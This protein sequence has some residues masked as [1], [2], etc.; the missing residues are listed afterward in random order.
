MK[1]ILQKLSLFVLLGVFFALSACAKVPQ[2]DRGRLAKRIMQFEPLP[3]QQSFL[4]EVHTIR[5]GA[6]G[7]DGQSAGG[8]CGCN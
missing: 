2:I 6:A 8:G 1:K 4:N 5:E 7:G 3:E